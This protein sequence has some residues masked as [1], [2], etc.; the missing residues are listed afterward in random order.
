VHAHGV[1]D[2]RRQGTRTA[3]VGHND[4]GRRGEQSL[5]RS[6]GEHIRRAGEHRRGRGRRP[7]S[8]GPADGRPPRRRRSSASTRR[9]ADADSQ[10]NDQRRPRAPRAATAC[11]AGLHPRNTRAA[12]PTIPMQHGRHPFR[13]TRP[14][15]HR[16]QPA[17]LLVQAETFILSCRLKHPSLR[18]LPAFHPAGGHHRRPAAGTASGRPIELMTQ[19][20]AVA[21]IMVICS[22]RPAPRKQ[23]SAAPAGDPVARW[24]RHRSTRSDL[25]RSRP[26]AQ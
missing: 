14:R 12:G 21:Q 20:P 3:R 26:G 15:C 7:G 13:P 10:R 22:P 23:L 16:T 17:F 18:R 25:R 5:R 1:S 9:C 11:R 2:R 8:R 4:H 24:V 19:L 6:S